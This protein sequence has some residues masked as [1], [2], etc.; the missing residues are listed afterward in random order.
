MKPQFVIPAM[1]QAAEFWPESDWWEVGDECLALSFGG[2]VNTTAL[3]LLLLWLNRKIEH[4]FSDLGPGAEHPRTTE[5]IAQYSK[6]VKSNGA[7][8]TIIKP[9]SVYHIPSMR[10][11]L[12][13]Y[14][15]KYKMVP[16]IP[17]PRWCTVKWKI[18]PIERYT[19]LK[20]FALLLGIDA[21]ERRQLR[22]DAKRFYPLVEAEIDRQD[23][24]EIIDA[25]GLCNPGKSG[26]MFCPR[27]T[28]W[29]VYQAWQEGL[30]HHRIQV[31]EIP[32]KG[33]IGPLRHGDKLTRE[34]IIDWKHGKNIPD[35]NE[36]L[37]DLP[38]ACK[39]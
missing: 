19:K 37:E 22:Q 3:S 5:F 23:C 38:C 28:K 2:G 26:C 7:R 33:K 16:R 6:I 17:G 12:A 24:H 36:K 32:F 4:I 20:T 8:F 10:L 11:P 15:H 34:M 14:I 1:E 29:Y 18:D 35:P 27:V 39:W 30:I 9:D 21:G 31:E 25:F 13:D